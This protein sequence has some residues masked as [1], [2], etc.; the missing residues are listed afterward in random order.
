MKLNQ[1]WFEWKKEIK[2]YNQNRDELREIYETE[3]P[4]N[5]YSGGFSS[6]YAD[7]LDYYDLDGLPLGLPRLKH[8]KKTF[9]IPPLCDA[10]Q[11]SI[12]MTRL[13]IES[14]ADPL[15]TSLVFSREEVLK[16]LN[17]VPFIMLLQL[18]I[19]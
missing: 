9:L 12:E 15:D 17:I 10:A 3:Y 5:N 8:P 4:N 14:G 16:R 19:I 11:T 18:E 7:E 2:Q 13:L 6:Y 1:H